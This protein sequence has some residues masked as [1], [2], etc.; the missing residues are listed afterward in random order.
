MILEGTGPSKCNAQATR[1]TGGVTINGWDRIRPL[2]NLENQSK[3]Y[4]HSFRVSSEAREVNSHFGQ[5]VG[6][7]ECVRQDKGDGGK[8]WDAMRRTGLC[9]RRQE[10]GMHLP[11]P[12]FVAIPTGFTSQKWLNVIFPK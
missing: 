11:Q 3:P 2:R 12:R 10:S 8:L 4:S 7:M 6:R 1:C 9:G 5:Q